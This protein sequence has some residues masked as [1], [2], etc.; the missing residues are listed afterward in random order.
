MQLQ[1]RERD[2]PVQVGRR[3]HIAEGNLHRHRHRQ[4]LP[5]RAAGR[6]AGPGHHVARP[7]TAPGRQ[8]PASRA[9]TALLAG[10]KDRHA[11][12][13][14]KQVERRGLRGGRVRTRGLRT[15]GWRSCAHRQP[16]S[17]AEVAARPLD[18]Q[19]VAKPSSRSRTGAAWCSRSCPPW[20]G[21]RPSTGGSRDGRP[22]R[23]TPRRPWEIRDAACPGIR[24]TRRVLPGCASTL[25]PSSPLA[26]A[27]RRP[28]RFSCRDR[29]LRALMYRFP[30]SWQRP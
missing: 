16:A 12:V 29:R 22:N 21:K 1:V 8:D 15:A 14:G 18:Q 24:A 30:S 3:D 27:R 25:A 19:G 20:R 13:V 28:G 26:A 9:L 2:C 5:R 6:R 11:E 7:A 4:V 23:A 10:A 17:G